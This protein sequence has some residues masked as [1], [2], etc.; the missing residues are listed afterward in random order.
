MQKNILI[1]LFALVIFGISCDSRTPT[2]DK[3]NNIPPKTS[4][5][6]NNE[7]IPGVT[8]EVMQRLLDDCTF[9]DYIFHNLPISLSQDE[10]PSI[11]QNVL[12]IEFNRP[13]VRIPEGCRPIARKFFQINGE[14]VYDVD[15]YFTKGCAFY[16]FVKDNKPVYAN[17]ISKDGVAFYNNMISM[18]QKPK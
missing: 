1:S 3:T 6:Q 15:V 7:P 12:Y 10:R 9:I 13:V 14:I 18:V 4:V 17:Y 2:Q 11:Q 8:A 16:V 5:A